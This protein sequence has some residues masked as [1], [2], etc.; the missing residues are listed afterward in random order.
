MSSEF[1]V[2]NF[3]TYN[4]I[5]NP[6]LFMYY[7]LFLID[8]L[9][10]DN[11][12]PINI[13][14]L[15]S[16]EQRQSFVSNVIVE[17]YACL[18]SMCHY[19]VMNDKK[20]KVSLDILNKYNDSY[21]LKSYTLS[22][23]FRDNIKNHNNFMD[24]LKNRSKEIYD[25]NN[26]VDSDFSIP[27]TVIKNNI[28]ILKSLNEGSVDEINLCNFIISM[29]K[30]IV[31]ISYYL[32]IKEKDSAV[33]CQKFLSRHNDL[34][35]DF[36]VNNVF[37]GS[38]L[39]MID[40]LRK[41]YTKIDDLNMEELN[42][43][44]VMLLDEKLIPLFDSLPSNY[45]NI[46]LKTDYNDKIKDEIYLIKTQLDEKKVDYFIIINILTQIFTILDNVLNLTY[47]NSNLIK[48]QLIYKSF[49]QYLLELYDIIV[50]ISEKDTDQKTNVKQIEGFSKK[51]KCGCTFF[52]LFLFILL[53]LLLFNI[54][55]KKK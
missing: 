10:N 8:T 13:K 55:N 49:Y 43:K 17:L 54:F 3:I 2:P 25:N 11:L 35:V 19:A 32:F 39:D 38:S 36:S 51:K 1:N 21:I 23:V 41:N 30:N 34:M 40:V 15:N 16:V 50:L 27:I 4:K 53:L 44:V 7:N 31:D 52:K 47:S 20:Y 18:I 9:N 48:I 28:S 24:K 42:E 33:I 45:N 26:F 6:S 12:Y 22:S 46:D 37:F 14:S 5:I 29:Y